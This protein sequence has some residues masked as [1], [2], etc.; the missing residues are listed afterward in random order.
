MIGTAAPD[1]RPESG[2]ADC[3]MA[4]ASPCRRKPPPEPSARLPP[5]A[6]KALP[7]PPIIM[8][9]IIVHQSCTIVAMPSRATQLNAV[10][11]MRPTRGPRVCERWPAVHAET[12]YAAK[13]E[14]TATPRSA[15]LK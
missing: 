10:P 14:A 15:G 6:E 3:F 2:T 7:T 13:N 11:M 4:N 8:S 12:P 5:T 1:R 9:A